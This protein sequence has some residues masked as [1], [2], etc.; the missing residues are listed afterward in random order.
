MFSPAASRLALDAVVG[1]SPPATRLV[2]LAQPLVCQVQQQTFG[3][4]A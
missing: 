2:R 4:L 3:G 1:V